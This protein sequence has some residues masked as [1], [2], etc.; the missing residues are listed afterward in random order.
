MSETTIRQYSSH[1]VEVGAD[2]APV[3]PEGKQDFGTSLTNAV[4]DNPASAALIGMGA[5]WLFFGGSKISLFGHRKQDGRVRHDGLRQEREEYEMRFDAPRSSGRETDRFGAVPGRIESAVNEATG[6]VGSGARLSACGIVDGASAVAD[7]AS[8]GYGAAASYAG[9]AASSVGTRAYD[10]GRAGSRAI[11]SQAGN[12][13]QTV[14]EFFEDQPLALGV[15]GLVLGAGVASLLPV[16]DVERQY[17]GETSD[18]LKAQARSAVGEKLSEARDLAST[19][20]DEVAREA[21]AQGLTKANATVVAADL[22]DRVGNVAGAAK[23]GLA[24][25]PADEVPFRG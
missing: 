22:K 23:E 14:G 18:E 11:R 3:R 10:A 9:D 6:A 16:T 5:A 20:L 7:A 24:E 19:A 21:E 13:Q 12:V 25:T 4:R 2:T 15:L 8:Q 17:L 1:T